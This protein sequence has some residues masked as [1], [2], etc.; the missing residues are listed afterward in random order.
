MVE[1]LQN[2]QEHFGRWMIAGPEIAHLVEEFEEDFDGTD[3]NSD[4]H[5]EQTKTVQEKFVEDVRSLVAV[6]EEMRKL[7]SNA[8]CSCPGEIPI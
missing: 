3:T 4:R 2:T 1:L 7:K 8:E 5:H 6:I